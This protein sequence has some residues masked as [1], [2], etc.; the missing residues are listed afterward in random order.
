M[1]E[2]SQRE[3]VH[4]CDCCQKQLRVSYLSRHLKTYLHKRNVSK[5][6]KDEIR[7]RHVSTMDNDEELV[8]FCD[9][10]QKQLRASYL[11]RHLRTYLHKR[12]VSKINKD[13]I[14]KR[15][16]STM[17]NDEIRKRHVSTM[18]NDEIRK[19]HVSTMNN[20]EIRK[21]LAHSQ[22]IGRRYCNCN[23]NYCEKKLDFTLDIDTLINDF[24]SNIV[25]ARPCFICSDDSTCEIVGVKE[26][27]EYIIR[28]HIPFHV[29]E[30]DCY[31][32]ETMPLRLLT[33]M[34]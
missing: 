33:S 27:E 29:S 26:N 6:N 7:K 4:F 21:R 5:I 19:R 18:D 22:L 20:D 32:I 25:M 15:H 3:L 17:N 10:C 30:K 9:C 24:W 2:E 1:K 28:R 14:R 11:W 16:V 23:A 12:N 13:E 31:L 34:S 8:H